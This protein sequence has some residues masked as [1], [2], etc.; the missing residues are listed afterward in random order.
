MSCFTCLHH[1]VKGTEEIGKGLCKRYPSQV[2]IVDGVVAYLWPV[3]KHDEDC[4]EYKDK[5]EGQ[6]DTWR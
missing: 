6:P 1:D 2:L 4:G 3:V 5:F